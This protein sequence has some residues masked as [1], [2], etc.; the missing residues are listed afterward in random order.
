[1]AN[2][3]LIVLGTSSQ[4]PTRHRNHNGYLLRWD[5]H[6]LL[7][8]PGEGTQRQMTLANVAVSTITHVLIS[9]FHGDHCLG[10]AGICQ[11][12]SLDNVPHDVQAYY[13]DSG[14]VFYDRLRHASIFFDAASIIKNP[15]TEGG[16]I[17]EEKNWQLT[18]RKLDHGVDAFGYRLE[19][20][21]GRTMLPDELAARG[22]K[23]AAIGQLVREGSVVIDG[24]RTT[25]DEVSVP[26]PGQAF[27]FIMDTRMCDSA[28]ELARGADLIVCESTYL[29]T[30]ADKAHDPGHLTASQAATIA[31]EAGVRTLVLAHFSQRYPSVEPFLEEARAIHPDV[32]AASDLD[33]I[34]VPK[35]R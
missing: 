1:M 15:I 33:V 27:A 28:F 14:Q 18:T 29:S 32:I 21:A 16:L 3:E 7:F 10:F 26:K 11:R 5:E 12:I 23:G 34:P 31:K 24:K 2:R 9:H 25:L 6:G 30:D 8:D 20:R 19:E 35:R 17:G 4:V 22:I 13:P